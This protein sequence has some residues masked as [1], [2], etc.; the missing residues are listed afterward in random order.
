MKA[1]LVIPWR[2]HNLSFWPHKKTPRLAVRI[3]CPMV[4]LL[5]LLRYRKPLF[6]ALYTP[7]GR[8]IVCTS[9][10]LSSVPQLL[11][12][13]WNLEVLCVTLFSPMFTPYY[14]SPLIRGWG[15]K[16]PW[17]WCGERRLP[18]KAG[19]E[20]SRAAGGSGSWAAEWALAQ[21]SVCSM[22]LELLAGWLRACARACTCSRVQS[23]N[24]Q[25]HHTQRVKIL[26]I[27]TCFY[28]GWW[29]GRLRQDKSATTGSIF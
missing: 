16:G 23:W 24:V 13:W 9:R 20:A 27:K 10:P 17:W 21:T 3:Y 22:Q 15:G 28:T 1:L 5:L 12:F 6:P 26:H 18:G 2:C 14:A 7:K 25:R 11:R 8:S 29:D 19:T 4:I